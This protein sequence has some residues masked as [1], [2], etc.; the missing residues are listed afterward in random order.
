MGNF[1]KAQT[2]G[3]PRSRCGAGRL[4]M[5]MQPAS[6]TQ[7]PGFMLLHGIGMVPSM[8]LSMGI[9]MVLAA[10]LA[11]AGAALRGRRNRD[12]RGTHIGEHEQHGK[13]LAKQAQR[14]PH[15]IRPA[16]AGVQVGPEREG[17]RV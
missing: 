15:L 8:P 3:V 5:K 16:P 7:L 1:T 2:S 9:I 14:H 4:T 12:D 11:R 6:V 17:L 13:D 10:P